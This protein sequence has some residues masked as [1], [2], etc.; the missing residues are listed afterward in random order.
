[1]SES[2]SGSAVFGN[3]NFEREKRKM[4]SKLGRNWAELCGESPLN[5]LQ[6]VKYLINERHTHRY[7]GK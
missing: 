1:M 6:S 2:E 4:H 5:Y 3:F 7:T